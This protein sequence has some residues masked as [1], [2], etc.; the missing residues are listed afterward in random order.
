MAGVSSG[1]VYPAAGV[2]CAAQGAAIASTANTNATSPDA[3]DRRITFML[4]KHRLG[5]FRAGHDC[6]SWVLTVDSRAS[7]DV[8]RLI[9]TISVP[10]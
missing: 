1:G 8:L 4:L 5:G 7:I 2:T 9:L 10:S 3:E 6:V